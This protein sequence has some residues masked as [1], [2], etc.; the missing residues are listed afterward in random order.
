[1]DGF[2][3]QYEKYNGKYMWCPSC[4]YGNYW[5]KSN[6]EFEITIFSEGAKQWLIRP[7]EGQ[8]ERF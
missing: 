6:G 5:E 2:P 1:M 7:R 4:K 8:P 3:A